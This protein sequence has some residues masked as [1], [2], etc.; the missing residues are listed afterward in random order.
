MYPTNIPRS[1]EETK[2]QTRRKC[3]GRD[4][5]ERNYIPAKMY[6]SGERREKLHS[7]ENVLVERR[8][9][10]PTGRNHTGCLISDRCGMYILK[11]PV[12]TKSLCRSCRLGSKRATVRNLRRYYS[13][14]ACGFFIFRNKGPRESTPFRESSSSKE[15]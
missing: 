5:G 12:H 10:T 13:I 3:I 11:I 8:K 6:R 4:R 15:E 7:D 1:E 9:D 2:A 14:I